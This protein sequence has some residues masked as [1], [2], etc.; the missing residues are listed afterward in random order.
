M[1]ASWKRRWPPPAVRFPVIAGAGSNNTQNRR[2]TR[3]RRRTGRRPGVALRHA[4]LSQA[5]TGRPGRAL[6]G[7]PRCRRPSDNPVRR[8][9]AHRLRDGRRNDQA[10]RRSAK[11]CRLKDAT[12]DHPAGKTT[13]APSGRW[14]HVLSGDDASQAAFS[15]CR[16]GRLHSV[17]A[18]VTPALCAALHKA[19][20]RH[21]DAEIARLE[22]ILVNLFTRRCSSK[23][24]PIPVKRTALSPRSDDRRPA[25][26]AHA[27]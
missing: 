10:A 16:R 14:L 17:T 15:P 2:R 9:I 26:A 18:N 27:A 13:A 3:A 8:A 7:D 6:H 5:D 19:C 20:D 25:A 11:D 1:R 22:A 12:G 24:I 23:P 4:L 21:D